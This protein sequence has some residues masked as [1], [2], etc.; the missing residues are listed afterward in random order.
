[1]EFIQKSIRKTLYFE[2]THISKV[3]ELLVL[4]VKSQHARQHKAVPI[5]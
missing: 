1:M 5:I 4:L 2:D 3:Y